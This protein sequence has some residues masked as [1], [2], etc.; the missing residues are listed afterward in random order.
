M[1]KTEVKALR[2]FP[3]PF[4]DSPDGRTIVREGDTYQAPSAKAAQ[5]LVEAGKAELSG[6]TKADQSSS[7]TKSKE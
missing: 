6:S 3:V 1:A 2:D 5:A 4:G 7:K